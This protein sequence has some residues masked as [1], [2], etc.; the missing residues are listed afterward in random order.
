[1]HLV[2]QSNFPVYIINVIYVL[3]TLGVFLGF[4]VA[5]MHSVYVFITVE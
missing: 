2:H 1:M 5:I 3:E 4:L